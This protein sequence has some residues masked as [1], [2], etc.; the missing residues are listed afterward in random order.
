MSELNWNNPAS[1]NPPATIRARFV[2]PLG[3]P[4]AGVEVEVVAQCGPAVEF[5]RHAE[6]ERDVH[7]T[8]TAEVHQKVVLLVT[9]PRLFSS[10]QA[11]NLLG[12]EF[13]Q[14][15]IRL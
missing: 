3:Q 11:R 5:V 8:R 15:L 10:R 13:V 6:Q 2:D 7:E 14:G 9:V 12:E 4:V 1:A